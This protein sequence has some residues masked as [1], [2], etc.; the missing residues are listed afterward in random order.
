LTEELKQADKLLD[1]ITNDLFKANLLNQSPESIKL[2]EELK[3]DFKDI[4]RV[5]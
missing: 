3:E 1:E 5:S 2:E 4:F